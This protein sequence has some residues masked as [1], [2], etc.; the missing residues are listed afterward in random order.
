M[1]LLFALLVPLFFALVFILDSFCVKDIFKKPWIGMITSAIASMIV[2]IPLPFVVVQLDLNLLSLQITTMA[3]L[4]GIIIQFNQFLYYEALNKSDPSVIAAYWNMVPAFLPVASHFVLKEILST[5]Q[6]SGILLLILASI[7]M[8][9]LDI[10]S[11]SKPIAFFLILAASCLQ[12]IAILMLDTVYERVNFYTGFL[13]FST[14]LISAGFM[15]LLFKEKRNIFKEHLCILR[16]WVAL[17]FVIETLNLLGYAS[18]Q[19]AL[20]LGKAS[21]VGSLES[22]TPAFVLVIAAIIYFAKGEKYKLANFEY[23]T[24]KIILIMLMIAGVA[25]I[26]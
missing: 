21:L 25:L 2:F 17:F 18:L 5:S 14:G 15:P 8:C 10:K 12:V 3:L 7:F 9:M 16:R 11:K 26:S 22:T 19:M 4:A 13:L 6:Y 1:W 23:I 24:K 20:R